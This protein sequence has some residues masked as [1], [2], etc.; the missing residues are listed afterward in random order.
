MATGVITY[1]I[2]AHYSNRFLRYGLRWQLLDMSPT[3]GAAL[4]MAACVAAVS[5]L[6]IHNSV[7]ALAAQ[8]ASGVVSYVALCAALRLPAFMELSAL[9]TTRGAALVKTWRTR[10]IA[11]QGPTTSWDDETHV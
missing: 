11:P 10:G 6:R 7:L 4:V 2:S 3:F 8:V 1:A 9:A 5:W